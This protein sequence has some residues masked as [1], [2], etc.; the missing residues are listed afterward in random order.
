MF[1]KLKISFKGSLFESLENI[2]NNGMTVL[3]EAR[4]SGMTE[5]TECA[6]NVGYHSLHVY[7]NILAFTESI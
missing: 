6:Y 1:P 3:K 2:Q 7:D 5:A 4:F